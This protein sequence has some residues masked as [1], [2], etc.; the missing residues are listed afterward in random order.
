MDRAA[1]AAKLSELRISVMPILEYSQRE[2]KDY[3]I[4]G[5]IHSENLERLLAA[6]ISRCNSQDGACNIEPVEEYIL[7]CAAWLHDMGNIAA[8][9]DHNRK[10][11][12]MIDELAPSE[13]WGLD[14]DYVESV[15]QVCLAHPR[16]VRIDSV[17]LEIPYRNTFLKLRYITAIFR[18][19]DAG[20]MSSKRAPMGVYKIIKGTLTKRSDRIWRSYQAVR[21]VSFL[22]SGTSI[23]VTV[24]DK[25]KAACAVKELQTEFDEVK[26]VLQ[27]YSLPYTDIQVVREDIAPYR[28]RVRLP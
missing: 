7:I 20:D 21:D 25:R 22:P 13:I 24:K 23:I 4:H 19:A 1:M 9:D 28:G 18:I 16:H 6:I 15:K 2:L 17:P 3:T 8:R 27:R 12:E 14:P 5:Q 10:T 11:C 26:A